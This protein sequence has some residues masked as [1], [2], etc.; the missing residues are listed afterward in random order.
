M[1]KIMKKMEQVANSHHVENIPKA[2]MKRAAKKILAQH[3][4]P[5]RKK[6]LVDSKAANDFYLDGMKKTIKANPFSAVAISATVGCISA[7][8][9]F[10]ISKLYLNK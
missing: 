2:T 8:A 10:L 1:E 6:A 9:G 7:V 4:A 3:A 5:K